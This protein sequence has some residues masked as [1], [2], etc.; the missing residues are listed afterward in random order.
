MSRDVSRLRPVFEES[1]GGEGGGLSFTSL[2][3]PGLNLGNPLIVNL[4]FLLASGHFE[5]LT[6]AVDTLLNL[7]SHK[8]RPTI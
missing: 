7:H 8:I 3:F 6:E 4:T 2:L 5:K 1:K